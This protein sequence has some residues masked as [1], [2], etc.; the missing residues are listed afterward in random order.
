MITS[1]HNWAKAA[2]QDKIHPFS[3]WIAKLYQYKAALAANRAT[4]RKTIVKGPAAKHRR[5]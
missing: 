3:T 1:N 2:Q 5:N 4:G